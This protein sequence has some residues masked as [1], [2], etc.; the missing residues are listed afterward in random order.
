MDDM[1][2]QV[3]YLQ[4]T[5]SQLQITIA[6]MLS[7]LLKEKQ[8]PNQNRDKHQK[9]KDVHDKSKVDAVKGVDETI[10][11]LSDDND[12]VKV[13]KHSVVKDPSVLIP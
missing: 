3:L 2:N 7:I 11:Q 4:K 6:N 13:F 1:L 10:D 12:A 9:R 8:T 5:V